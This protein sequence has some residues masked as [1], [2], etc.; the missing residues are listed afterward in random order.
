MPGGRAC[1]REAYI[2]IG[3]LLL[4]SSFCIEHYR[5][6]FVS[7]P[8]RGW[9]QATEHCTAQ[10]KPDDWDN[11]MFLVY[12]HCLDNMYPR[13]F[14]PYLYACLCVLRQHTDSTCFIFIHPQNARVRSVVT[15]RS[16]SPS[17]ARISVRT[18]T[19][20]GISSF[21]TDAGRLQLTSE[22]TLSPF[23][24][25]RFGC[26]GTMLV[27]GGRTEGSFESLVALIWCVQYDAVCVVQI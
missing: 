25:L 8:L 1:L 14:L 27:Q 10:H 21:D 17:F 13:L 22:L 19:L 7:L 4:S 12:S 24:T 11:P 23:C 3:L 2:C 9:N 16:P 6:P 15:V 20:G 18:G 5:R 26:V